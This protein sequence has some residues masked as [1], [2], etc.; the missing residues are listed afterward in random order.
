M[1]VNSDPEERRKTTAIE[2]EVI[3]EEDYES[4]LDRNSH[5]DLVSYQETS[6]PRSPK[7]TGG[8]PTPKMQPANSFKLN[9]MY[10]K[11]PGPLAKRFMD[12]QD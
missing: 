5:E 8:V 1:V 4:A 9:K 3:A 10:S 12:I 2:S 6:P 11:T 7:M